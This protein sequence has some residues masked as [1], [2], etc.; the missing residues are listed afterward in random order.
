[1]GSA[2]LPTRLTTPEVLALARYSRAT[3]ARRIGAGVMPKPIDRGA[4]GGIFDRDAVLKALG[5]D[6]PMTS[7]PIDRTITADAFVRRR[8]ELAAERRGQ[9]RAAAEI[10]EAEKAKKD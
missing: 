5:I 6:Q 10:R 1:M 9:T 8:A 2:D 7:T 4:D 3:L